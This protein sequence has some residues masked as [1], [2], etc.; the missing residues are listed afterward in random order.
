MAHWRSY[1]LS[2]AIS[3]AIATN[4]NTYKTAGT[5]H[6]LPRQK[7]TWKSQVNRQKSIYL[8]VQTFTNSIKSHSVLFPQK[9]FIIAS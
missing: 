6:Y 5:F 8:T 9:A 2:E 7:Q 4:V 3:E 1:E